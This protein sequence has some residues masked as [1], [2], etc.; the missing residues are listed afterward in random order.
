MRIFPG[1]VWL[2]VV[3]DRAVAPGP[4]DPHTVGDQPGVGLPEQ[5]GV[6]ESQ[7]EEART[8]DVAGGQEPAAVQRLDDSARGFRYVGA[9]LSGISSSSLNC[10]LAR[11]YRRA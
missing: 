2:G 7:A 1:D 8:Q 4:G 11:P 6:G 3:D 9:G 5:R 10:R